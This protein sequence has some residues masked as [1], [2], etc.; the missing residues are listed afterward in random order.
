VGIAMGIFVH[1]QPLGMAMGAYGASM[2]VYS[3][4]VARGHE[5]VFPKNTA[6]EVSIGTR[7]APPAPVT[8]KPVDKPPA[9]PGANIEN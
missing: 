5:L 8:T 6:M 3:H 4:F 7:P 9:Y 1:S 2:S